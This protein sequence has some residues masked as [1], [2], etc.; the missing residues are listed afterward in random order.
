MEIISFIG[1]IAALALLVYQKSEE[2]SF[3]KNSREF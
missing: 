2:D 3:L 1:L